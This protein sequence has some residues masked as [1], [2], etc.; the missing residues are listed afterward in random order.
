MVKRYKLP[1]GGEMSTR[2]TRDV[3]T[4]LIGRCE[5]YRKAV[6]RVDPKSF[7]HKGKIVFPF[8][9]CIYVRGWMLTKLTVIIISE[10][11]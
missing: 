5:V 11:I 4:V 7:H 6:K 8:F 9:F 1:V 10:Y 3:M 2:D